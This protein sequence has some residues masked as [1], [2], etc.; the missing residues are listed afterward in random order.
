M[1]V[2]TKSP[3]KDKPLRLP[4]QSLEQEV[5]CLRA[6]ALGGV[7]PLSVVRVRP[8]LIQLRDD[9]RAYPMLGQ[10]KIAVRDV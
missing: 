4:G 2:P 7:R 10:N 3:I 8:N 6:M 5:A 1:N 9:P